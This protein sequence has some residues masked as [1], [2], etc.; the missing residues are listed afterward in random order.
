MQNS[1]APGPF[2]DRRAPVICTGLFP[3][4]P[5]PN[6][7]GTVYQYYYLYNLKFDCSEIVFCFLRRMMG[8]P[9][10]S[11]EAYRNAHLHV[12][13]ELTVIFTQFNQNRNGYLLLA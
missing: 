1:R 13:S 7:V 9:M 12:C 2:T 8:M 4:P 6:A 5:P 3:P 11:G 10:H